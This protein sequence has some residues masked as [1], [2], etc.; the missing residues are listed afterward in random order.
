MPWLAIA[1]GASALSS[2]FGA[3][4][5]REASKEA[6]ALGKANASYIV[7]ETAEQQRRLKFEH[8][9]TRATARAGVAASGFRSGKDSIGA[10]QKAYQTTLARVQK[11][12]LAWLGKS[13]RMR[14][15]I[16]VR[17]GQAESNVLRSQSASMF[18]SALTSAA[19]S[20][21]QWNA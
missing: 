4:R 11:E 16:A 17:G 20:I 1:A 8:S 3:K 7:Q 12:E 6:L 14:A 18:G 21:Y 13:G 5:T 19:K 9:R 15:D 10:S 2:L